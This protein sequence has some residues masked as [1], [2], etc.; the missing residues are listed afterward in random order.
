LLEQKRQQL[1]RELRTW[2]EETKLL[3]PG[4][5]LYLTIAIAPPDEAVV[6]VAAAN[7]HDE[8][9]Y[10][11]E[12]QWKLEEADWEFLLEHPWSNPDHRAVIALLKNRSNLPTN[13]DAIEEKLGFKLGVGFRKSINSALELL[14]KLA[15]RYVAPHSPQFVIV[16]VDMKSKL[17]IGERRIQLTKYVR[18]L[19]TE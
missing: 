15:G 6:S 13:R 2:V 14:C 12:G 19:V 16:D 3:K 4:E 11:I 8:P 5:F 1:H 17:P 9:K 10:R 7:P 18:V